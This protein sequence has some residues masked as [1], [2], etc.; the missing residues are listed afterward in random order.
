MVNNNVRKMAIR[1]VPFLANKDAHFFNL[2]LQKNQRTKNSIKNGFP[3][4][5][6]VTFS[7]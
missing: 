6:S 7:G 5:K 2:N 3:V 1:N 4:F